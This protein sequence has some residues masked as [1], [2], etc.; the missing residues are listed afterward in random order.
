MG[1]GETGDWAGATQRIVKMIQGGDDPLEGALPEGYGS[2]R[3]LEAFAREFEAE[4]GME[5]GMAFPTMLAG[6]SGAC[7]GAF[8][9]P[10][11]KNVQPSLALKWTSLVIQ[12]IGVAEAGQQKS[13]LLNEVMD[14][15]KRALDRGPAA[16][17]RRSL[18]EKLRKEAMDGFGSTG[19]K[20]DGDT[21][22]WEKV[23]NGG[24]CP[25][26][27]TDQGTP[28]GIRNNIVR[29]GG[30]RVILTAEPDVLAEISQY[31]NRG[32]GG[33]IGLFLR[34]WNQ[35]DLAVDRAGTDALYVREPS[36]PY[37]IMLQPDSFQKHTGGNGQGD[38]D[39]IDRGL[40]SR[41]WLWKS[42]RVPIS[43]LGD[44]AETDWALDDLDLSGL[45]LGATETGP[46]WNMRGVL[47]ERMEAVALRSN[48]YRVAKGLE[49]AWREHK[50]LWMPRPE[51]VVRE[52]LE[53]DGLAGVKE[54]WRVQLMR[55]RIRQAVAEADA[56]T[57]GVATLLDPMAVRFTDHVM[58]IAAVL[59]LASDPDAK[60]VDT[61]HVEDVATRLM[62]WL[63][64]GWLRV[65]RERLE[66]SAALAVEESVL[67]NPKGMDLSAGGVI[68]RSLAKLTESDAPK[69]MGGF[70]P[71]E[72]FQ[73]ARRAMRSSK[74]P[75]AWITEHLHKELAEVVK[76]GLVQEVGAAADAAGKVTKRYRLAPGV[77]EKINN[78][79]Q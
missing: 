61:G 60:T 79:G 72:I 70:L 63:W 28:E 75:S 38:D 17:H 11:V 5:L 19:L 49:Q 40:F 57:R 27:I 3:L 54:G 36:L 39:F 18:V 23:Y 43:D 35:E 67:K 12:F 16:E 62:P 53:F 29:H 26:S 58:R 66:A 2:Q 32:A 34:G 44:G 15:L 9:A 13:T 22:A 30:H 1:L 78:S 24:L 33:S 41:S 25:S 42:E 47:A 46:L 37:V 31:Q 20:V 68:L 56:V 73:K 59:T 55:A 77:Y 21:A 52:K 74:K 69:A 76:E 48:P 50:V 71:M 51:D 8:L 4:N 10:M 6:F 45:D 7:Q 65:M 14:P 64:A